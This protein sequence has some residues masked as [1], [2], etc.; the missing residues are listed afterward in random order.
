M[1]KTTYVASEAVRGEWL[2]LVQAEY[3]SAAMTQ[4][5]TL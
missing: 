2:R 3:T 5:F 1:A 4:N